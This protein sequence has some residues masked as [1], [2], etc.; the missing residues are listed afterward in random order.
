V[1][2]ALAPHDVSLALYLFDALPTSITATG[3]NW[4]AGQEDNEAAAV[5]HF[6][7]GRTAQIQVARFV[8]NKRRDVTIAGLDATL[9]FDELASTEQALRLW[10]P[11]TGTAVVPGERVDAL[12]AQC[13]DFVARVACG[14]ASSESGA[15]AVDVVRVLEAGERSMRLAGCAQPVAREGGVEVGDPAAGAVRARASFEAA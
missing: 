2:W 3:S 11:Q 5:L 9:T 6:P 12:Q 15:H 1:W 4:G 10:K 7:G 8:A 13:V 14:D